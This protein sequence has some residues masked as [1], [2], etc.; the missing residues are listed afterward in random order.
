MIKL[1]ALEEHF[2]YQLS[3]IE[4]AQGLDQKYCGENL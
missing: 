2:Y 3:R 1:M 4:R